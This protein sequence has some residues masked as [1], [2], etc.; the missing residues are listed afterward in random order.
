[1]KNLYANWG[2]LTHDIFINVKTGKVKY[3]IRN[4]YDTLIE[5]DIP[6]ISSKFIII[7][8]ELQSYITKLFYNYHT[9]KYT[10]DVYGGIMDI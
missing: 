6:Y 9:I 8:N 3:I 4:C 10:F 5:G 1:M 7:T 2:V